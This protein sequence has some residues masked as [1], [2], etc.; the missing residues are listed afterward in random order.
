VLLSIIL[1]VEPHPNWLL[2]LTT[3]GGWILSGRRLSQATGVKIAFFEAYVVFLPYWF[4]TDL[5]A[6]VSNFSLHFCIELFF[7]LG[8][9][10]GHRPTPFWSLLPMSFRP[11]PGGFLWSAISILLYTLYNIPNRVNTPRIPRKQLI[12]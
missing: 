11:D 6:G 1:I 7:I 4:V 5:A 8:H 12:L 10:A 3:T 2:V 9:S